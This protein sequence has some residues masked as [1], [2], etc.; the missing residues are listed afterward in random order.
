MEAAIDV[1]RYLRGTVSLGIVYSA[2]AAKDGLRGWSDAAYAD[3]KESARSTTGYGFMFCGGLISWNAKLQSY[4]AT[5]TQ[6]AEYGAASSASRECIWLRMVTSELGWKSL[7]P[8]QMFSDSS[9]ALSLMQHPIINGRTKHINVAFHYVR[10]QIENGAIKF[11]FVPTKRMLADLFTK[12]LPRD[13]FQGF[14]EEFGIL[15]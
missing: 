3:D 10:E 6:H 1:L 11:D 13:T 15:A 14:R 9:S 5:S 8:T 12:A 7:G 4:V 2:A